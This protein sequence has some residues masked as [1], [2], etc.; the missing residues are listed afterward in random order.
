LARHV[1][2]ATRRTTLAVLILPPS[3][4]LADRVLFY[5][6]RDG[7]APDGPARDHRFPA[8][9]YSALT[10][11]HRGRLHD[12]ATGAALPASTVSGV[13]SRAVL[14]RY[15]D[16]PRTTVAVLRPGALADLMR[17]PAAEFTDAWADAADLLPH[18][19]H[20]EMLERMAGPGSVARRIH[21]LEDVLL[22]RFGQAQG[23]AR[24]YTLAL[25][26]LVWRLPSMSVPQLAGH[27]GCSARSLQRRFADMFGASPRLLMR[28]ARL[29]LTMWHMQRQR[30]RLADVA[31]AAGYADAAH[32]AREVRTLAGLVPRALQPL[33]HGSDLSAW[34]FAAPQDALRP[35]P[36]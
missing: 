2:L 17:L 30:Q 25:Q 21:A 29:Q 23:H 19:L 33:L 8:N 4:A 34:A 36:P 18:A 9:L 32:L 7:H 20:D 1:P 3:P 13:M 6:T 26:S 11:T 28:L 35:M 10:I 24:P 14:R 16:T 22:R 5:V 27:F 12:A 15:V 31:R